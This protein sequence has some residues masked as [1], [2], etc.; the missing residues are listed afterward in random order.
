M[1]LVNIESTVMEVAA[2]KDASVALS[3]RS[4]R[5]EHSA[6][7]SRGG[8]SA[9]LSVQE[10][11]EDMEDNRL[12]AYLT[13]PTPDK[14]GFKSARAPLSARSSK[15]NM[16]APPAFSPERGPKQPFLTP[17]PGGT[18]PM[19]TALLAP[20]SSRRTLVQAPP[21]NSPLKAGTKNYLAE[22]IVPLLI[23]ALTQ[24][25]I[26][27]P[28]AS[29]SSPGP[30][31][32]MAKY[33]LR[34]SGQKDD[35]KISRVRGGNDVGAQTDAVAEFPLKTVTVDTEV[36]T[37]TGS[38][39]GLR[40][41]RSLGG[42][43]TPREAREININ[44]RVDGNMIPS[45]QVHRHGPIPE[46]PAR[47]EHY[48]VMLG[49]GAPRPPPACAPH[50][51]APLLPIGDGES[52]A[53]EKVSLLSVADDEEDCGLPAPSPQTDEEDPLHR[54]E[55]FFEG[56]TETKTVS[57]TIGGIPSEESREKRTTA[58]NLGKAL[59]KYSSAFLA[60]A[61][62]QAELPGLLMLLKP[63]HYQDAIRALQSKHDP[64]AEGITFDAFKEFCVAGVPV[65]ISTPR[66]GT[67]TV[68]V[69]PPL[70]SDVAEKAIRDVFQL[71]DK[72]GSGS[73]EKR[74]FIRAMR[75]SNHDSF[76]TA[77]NCFP[78]LGAMLKPRAY[79]SAFMEM[80]STQTGHVTFPEFRSFCVA[81]IVESLLRNV[82]DTM[83]ADGSGT[84]EKKEI[85]KTIHDSRK[86][87]V[88]H[89]AV[90]HFPALN[91]L[92][93]PLEYTSV[94]EKMNTGVK[95]HVT[96][97]EFHFFCT[98][99]VAETELKHVFES[100]DT[101]E[102]GYLEKHAIVQTFRQGPNP[103]IIQAIR[104]F[105][106]LAVMLRTPFYSDALVAFPTANQGFVSKAEFFQFFGSLQAQTFIDTE[107][108][109]DNE[110]VKEPAQERLVVDEAEEIAALEREL[111]ET[112]QQNRPKTME[113]VDS[114]IAD[115]FRA[116][117]TARNGS[118][119]KDDFLFACSMSPPPVLRHAIEQLPAL[120]FLT[121]T[122]QYEDSFRARCEGSITVT[123]PEL[124]VFIKQQLAVL[125][126]QMHGVESMLVEDLTLDDFFEN[127]S[128]LITH[129]T[130]SNDE[131]SA[132]AAA[133]PY[134]TLASARVTSRTSNRVR[135]DK[136]LLK[137][138]NM[139]D[140]KKDG[141]IDKREVLISLS[142]RGNAK[143]ASLLS[144]FEPLKALL[145]PST[146]E[147]ALSLMSTNA[148]NKVSF[149]EF[150]AFC[151]VVVEEVEDAV[152]S[153]DG[154][155]DVESDDWIMDSARVSSRVEDVLQ[156]DLALK[157]LFTALQGSTTKTHLEKR[158][159]LKSLHTD[160]SI[161]NLLKLEQSLSALAFPQTFG[162][163][164]D[165]LA[166]GSESGDKVSWLEFRAFCSS[167]SDEQTVAS[168]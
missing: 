156:R 143:I 116:F 122:R 165:A 45:Q 70:V 73:L 9:R 42:A 41:I 14:H 162:A 18:N 115:I 80:D 109:I 140:T 114:V 59:H 52:N 85:L 78:Q 101:D 36:Q 21:R 83:D 92:L 136:S 108:S 23:E 2:E 93:R 16:S 6:I 124:S 149:D 65:M 91:K 49:S 154:G 29:E 164:F 32:W 147:E 160:R 110:V 153:Q 86:L 46:G 74:E 55:I 75:I 20:L 104:K 69:A 89:D 71:I 135:M 106:S 5:S 95:G 31:V 84:L 68:P 100:L 121:Q 103:A 12:P 8:V 123:L 11:Q 119:N 61:D 150:R 158:H 28:E 130:L 99:T 24:L 105:P 34:R 107:K 129:S 131:D 126:S 7:S 82:F 81:T 159:V 63:R 90:Q 152:L 102:A 76:Q 35:Y 167:V 56:S 22:S 146:Y 17:L 64:H 51:D 60:A 94:F 72:D 53:Q 137:I 148:S 26:S 151:T 128:Q 138:F 13:A 132:C 40:G 1:P 113:E 120:T 142:G 111:A 43:T 127:V 57:S 161:V 125:V 19:A 67:M 66:E 10:V 168:I 38:G 134:D 144:Y 25:A 44:I 54:L 141:V 112:I 139:I 50:N 163:T 88:L 166:V 117:D 33:L 98:S 155:I 97:E 15:S 39:S 87:K 58:R 47:V 30:E 133:E 145:K 3:S 48:D 77:L 96:F 79:E 118:I 4:V 157:R 62:S 37:E 27:R